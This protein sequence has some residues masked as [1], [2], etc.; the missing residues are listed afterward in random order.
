MRTVAVWCGVL[1]SI[2]LSCSGSAGR[3]F[4]DDA[5]DG[6]SS[7]LAGFSGFAGRGGRA[8]TGGVA[9]RGGT[10]GQSGQPPQPD[11]GSGASGL[12]DP[13]SGDGQAC[14]DELACDD[15][16]ECTLDVCDDRGCSHPPVE[17]GADCGNP[18]GEVCSAPD[19]CD[20]AGVCVPNHAPEGTVCDGGRC[21][22][23]ACVA[24]EPGGCP[25]LVVT[26]LPFDTNW[27]TVG[28]INLYDGD[29]TCDANNTP[30]FAVV[31]VAPATGNY[32]FEATG[33]AGEDDPETTGG[34]AE[35]LADSVVTIADGA[36]EGRAA[37]QL[38]CNDDQPNG[39]RNSL[40][41]LQLEAGET[42]TVYA[43]ERDEE[44]GGSGTLS[45]RA[46]E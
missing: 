34:N 11:G 5:G 1:G 35:L 22:E 38:A 40:I 23:G 30:D 39:D 44:F 27:R 45:I 25:V 13:D 32:R 42:V 6:G 10:D 37:P 24:G 12:G 43:G 7:G 15:G 9:G 14:S 20:G 31:F 2:V 19:T 3:L 26:E 33:V 46:I 29:G 41:Q 4:S 28:G 18:N 17:A 16:N 36:C 21:T 8:G